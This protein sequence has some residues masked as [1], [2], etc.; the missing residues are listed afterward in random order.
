MTEIAQRTRPWAQEHRSHDPAARTDRNGED[1]REPWRSDDHQGRGEE[2]EEHVLDHVDEEVIVRPVVDRRRDGDQ[3]ARRARHRTRTIGARRRRRPPGIAA[4][5]EPGQSD[6]VRDDK[7]QR[8]HEERIERPVVHDV[9]HAGSTV[10]ELRLTA[11][12]RS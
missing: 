3:R 11:A 10:H 6:L 9:A 7:E 8:D 5:A 2:H 4:T 1:K 12:A